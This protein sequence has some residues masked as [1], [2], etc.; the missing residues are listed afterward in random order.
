MI[1]IADMI[2]GGI[3]KDQKTRGKH[4]IDILTDNIIKPILTHGDIE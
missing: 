2:R 4:V 3:S 1:I